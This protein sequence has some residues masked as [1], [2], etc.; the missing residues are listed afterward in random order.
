MIKEKEMSKLDLRAGHTQVNRPSSM[1]K[2][3]IRITGSIFRECLTT[4]TRP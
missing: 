2:Q 4:L 1:G 3:K